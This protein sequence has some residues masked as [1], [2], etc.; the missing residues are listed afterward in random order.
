VIVDDRPGMAPEIVA[1]AR[2]DGYT[3]LLYGSALWTLPLMRANVGYDPLRDFA[4]VSLVA[5]TPNILAVNPAVAVNTVPELIALAQAKPGQLN[6]ASGAAGSPNHIAGELF[7]AL[8]RVN[9]VRIPYKGSGPALNALI[10][11]QVELAFAP[12][13]SAMLH[14]RNGQLR[15][16]GVTSAEPSVLA[17]GVPT[18]AAAG[19]PGYESVAI[20]GVFAPTGISAALVSRLNKEIVSVVQR[21]DV[22]E[23]LINAG[24]EAVGSVCLVH[25]HQLVV[26]EFLQAENRL[27]KQRLQGR[28]NRFTDAERALLG[29]KAN[30]VGRKALKAGHRRIAGHVAVLA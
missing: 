17:P 26:T 13:A 29:R 16:L 19:L 23:R 15:A 3:L 5:S 12:A 9:I 27:L 8:A 2:P 24:S 21:S 7:N 11:G 30:A 20:Y 25:R 22:R 28:R 18:V 14:A 10:G 6:Y 4:A 1:K